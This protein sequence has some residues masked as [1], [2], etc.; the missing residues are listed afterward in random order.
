MRGEVYVTPRLKETL[1]QLWFLARRKWLFWL[2]VCGVVATFVAAV[3]WPSAAL[4]WILLL[5]LSVTGSIVPT[6]ADYV[7]SRQG[8]RD[9]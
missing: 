4:L 8:E 1:S 3:L 2:S 5:V 9:S 6:V 7:T